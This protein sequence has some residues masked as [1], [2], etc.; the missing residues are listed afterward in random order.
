V[1]EELEMEQT[2][3]TEDEEQDVITYQI[4]YYPADY[5][6]RG[7]LDKFNSKQLIIPEFQRNYVWDQVRASKL[8]E[9]FLLGL[10]VPGVFLYKERRTNKLWVVDGQQRII[11]AV[12]FFTGTFDENTF[13]LK[14]VHPRWEGKTYQELSDA[15]K[16]QID[17]SVLRATIVQQLDPDDD[18]SIYYVFERLNTGGMNLNPME[19]RKC[20]YFGSYFTLLER[21]N[22]LNHWRSI[23]G[24]TKP[25]KRY[26]DIELIL[27]VRALTELWDVY[28]KPMKGFLNTFMSSKN[29]LHDKEL[30]KIIQ[31][32]ES[33]FTNTCKFVVE[34]LGERPFHLKNR[35]NYA[36][37]DSV[38]AA[39]SIAFK[40][41]IA[42][43]PKR[44]SALKDNNDYIQACSI[45][46]SDEKV[47]KERFDFATKILAG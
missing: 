6:L 28:E 22:L 36:V 12:R 34:T 40:K 15:E 32:T 9:S 38:M 2:E 27:R 31:E 30:E 47:L 8:I 10:P 41:N 33:D 24:T 44:F 1:E 37:L 5:T 16:L 43:F 45:S 3:E 39:A 11:S 17:D 46:T 25:D 19:I 13:R 4:S 21:L 14:K 23:I 26:R 35:L 20:V 42:D 18:T 29:K 7:Y